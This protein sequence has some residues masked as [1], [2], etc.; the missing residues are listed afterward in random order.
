MHRSIHLPAAGLAGLLLFVTG[1]VS[2]ALADDIDGVQPAAM[3]Q[4]RINLVIRREAHGEPLIGKS[5][6]GDAFN[7]E[8]FLDTGA[9]SIALS[10]NT[11][12]LL[13]IH[14]EM[15]TKDEARFQDVG[16]GG[17]SEFAVSEPLYV[18]LAPMAPNVDVEEK[19]AIAT[20]YSLTVG[21]DRAEIGPLNSAADFLTSLALGDM[22]IVGMPAIAGKIV[23]LDPKDVN[24]MSDKIRTYVYD[25]KTA[26]ADHAPIPQISQHVKLSYVSFSR[27]TRISM[28]AQPPAMWANPM[29]GPNPLHPEGDRTASMI[30]SEHGKN[31]AGSWLLDT[32]AA[33][34]MISR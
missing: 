4:P 27:F 10:V 18:S 30:V 6:E 13:G 32:G 34:S 1:Y 22:D 21:P 9:S 5:A 11:A 26:A 2:S 7:V 29:I 16:V 28:G 25:A 14:R 12:Q 17:G 23:V 8:A 3:D 33:A 19:D 31:S 15:I 20:T 24:S